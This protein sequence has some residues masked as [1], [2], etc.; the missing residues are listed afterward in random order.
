MFAQTKKEGLL[1][2]RTLWCR[3]FLL[4]L[5]NSVLFSNFG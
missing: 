4:E 1:E 2:A 5:L 3:I